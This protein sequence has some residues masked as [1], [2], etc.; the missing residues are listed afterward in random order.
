MIKKSLKVGRGDED[1]SIVGC[2]DVFR[3]DAPDQVGIFRNQRVRTE[4]VC[5]ST[6]L[7]AMFVIVSESVL[8]QKD[9]S[10]E[11]RWRREMLQEAGRT[12]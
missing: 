12:N 9:R 3:V 10:Y 7:K 8:V 11:V 5:L 2:T 1:D 4:N 6:W